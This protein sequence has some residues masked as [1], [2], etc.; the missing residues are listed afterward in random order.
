MDA[1]TENKTSLEKGFWAKKSKL[2]FFWVLDELGSKLNLR[3]CSENQIFRIDHE[4]FVT[5]TYSN[6]EL[7]CS[8]LRS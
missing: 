4:G 3:I 2:K 1:L 8:G 6:R 5:F 7:L